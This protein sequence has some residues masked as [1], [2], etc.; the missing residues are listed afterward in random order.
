[1]VINLLVSN[2]IALPLVLVAV[3]LS[4]FGVRFKWRRKSVYSKRGLIIIP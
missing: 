3:V 2:L 4:L 1:M